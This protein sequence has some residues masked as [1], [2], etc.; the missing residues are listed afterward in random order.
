MYAVNEMFRLF[1]LPPE[2]IKHLQLQLDNGLEVP[3]WTQ[4]GP[5]MLDTDL[6]N[7]K[8]L[9]DGHKGT[10]RIYRGASN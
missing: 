6:I 2:A 1:K 7:A 9:R 5:A 3:N 8:P 4:T 10:V